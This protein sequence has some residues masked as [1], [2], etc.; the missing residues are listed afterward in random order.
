MASKKEE[1]NSKVIKTHEEFVIIDG[2]EDFEFVD[3][4]I[5]LFVPFFLLL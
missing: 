4:G 2:E 3:Q 1:T 5:F